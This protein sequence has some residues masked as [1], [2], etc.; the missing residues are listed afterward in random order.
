MKRQDLASRRVRAKR[1]FRRVVRDRR[2]S[3]AWANVVMNI[4]ELNGFSRDE[5]RREL[6]DACAKALADRLVLDAW[7]R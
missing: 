2:E 1:A 7:R 4:L 3:K 6:S 5:A